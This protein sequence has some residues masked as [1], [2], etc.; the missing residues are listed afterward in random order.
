MLSAK[1]QAA[2]LVGLDLGRGGLQLAL[3]RLPLRAQTLRSA[4]LLQCRALGRLGFPARRT[5]CVSVH[6]SCA[7]SIYTLCAV[8][9]TQACHVCETCLSKYQQNLCLFEECTYCSP[10]YYN[11]TLSRRNLQNSG[12]T[13]SGHRHNNTS[14]KHVSH[15]VKTNKTHWASCAA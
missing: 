12:Q 6:T 5:A 4:L 14:N 13:S 2:P 11:F 15:K 3:G 8:T 10:A 1:H 7:D 9:R